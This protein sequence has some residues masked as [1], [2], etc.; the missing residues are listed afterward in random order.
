MSCV[1]VLTPVLMAAWPALI[2]AGVSAAAS[3][4]YEVVAAR[5]SH[6]IEGHQPLEVKLEVP[7]SE[8]VTEQLGR[9]QRMSVT[10]EGVTVTFSPDARGKAEACV[11]GD[12]YSKEQLRALGEELSGRVVQQYVYQR[13]MSEIRARQFVVVEEETDSNRSIRLK[14]RHWEN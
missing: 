14:V 13:L 11:T 10:R 2:A 8:I 3:L 5:K 1:C 4:G 6:P 12:G 7:Q 9:D